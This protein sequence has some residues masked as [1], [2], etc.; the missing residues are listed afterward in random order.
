MVFSE[1]E[2]EFIRTPVVK[3]PRKT[4]TPSQPKPKAAKPKPD[5]PAVLRLMTSQDPTPSYSLRVMRQPVPSSSASSSYSLRSM[6]RVDLSSDEEDFSGVQRVKKVRISPKLPTARM[7]LSETRFHSQIDKQI[8]KR[9]YA[10]STPVSVGSTVRPTRSSKRL[11]NNTLEVTTTTITRK[12]PAAKEPE[13]DTISGGTATTEE[14]E[15]EEV[16]TIVTTK[17]LSTGERA[18]WHDIGWK[19]V[20]LAGFLAGV[21]V[22]GY[23]CYVSDLCSY[24]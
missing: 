21:G 20:A 24:C 16:V 7:G 2:E 1:E 5:T 18:T 17:N 4:K 19:E 22:L 10:S 15:E 11:A 8:D 13:D 14:E 23:I 9:K 3:K 12:P 6:R